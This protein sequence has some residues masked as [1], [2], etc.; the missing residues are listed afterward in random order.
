[1]LWLSVQKVSCCMVLF[2]CT[3]LFFLCSGKLSWP[4]SDILS[5]D[6]ESSEDE[7]EEEESDDES[8]AMPELF[9]VS[10][11]SATA[12]RSGLFS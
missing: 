2:L 7:E 4:L 10:M 12:A 8:D 5:E 9:F 3:Y 6:D 11:P 1:M